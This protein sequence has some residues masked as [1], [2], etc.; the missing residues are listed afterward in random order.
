MGPNEKCDFY[1][2]G[3]FDKDGFVGNWT[4]ASENRGSFYL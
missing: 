2:N 1:E 3:E 4:N